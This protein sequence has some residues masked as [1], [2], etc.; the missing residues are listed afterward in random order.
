MPQRKTTKYKKERCPPRNR[1]T[2][3]G[4]RCSHSQLTCLAKDA[5]PSPCTAVLC[6]F[7]SVVDVARRV[8]LA[9]KFMIMVSEYAPSNTTVRLTPALAAARLPTTNPRGRGRDEKS[10][11]E[12]EE[13]SEL[14][15]ERRV[16]TRREGLAYPS[17]LSTTVFICAG[18]S[19]LL[20]RRASSLSPTSPGE[21]RKQTHVHRITLSDAHC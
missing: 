7:D 12:G 2:G 21:Y 18:S 13:G 4:S 6:L 15:G 17:S 16:R 20:A 3:A 9:W 19:A 11:H 10:R 8:G 5:V 14:H 1:G